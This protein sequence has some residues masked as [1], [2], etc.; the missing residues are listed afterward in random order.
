MLLSG[1]LAHPE[2]GA[3]WHAHPIDQELNGDWVFLGI[4]GPRCHEYRSG[5]RKILVPFG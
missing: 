4:D 3:I 5:Y 2:V 1:A